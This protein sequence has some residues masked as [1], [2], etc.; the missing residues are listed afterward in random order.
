MSRERL[1]AIND[2]DWARVVER[3]LYLF[4]PVIGVGV[5]GVLQE[6]DPGVPGLQWGLVLFGTFGYTFLTAGMTV[7]LFLDA[8]RVRRQ[9]RASGQWQPNPWLNA[10]FAL[11]WAPVAGVVY[12][13][14][15]HRR[16]GTP[17]G[18]GGWWIVIAVSLAAT[19][20][21]AVAAAIGIVLAVPGL[22]TSAVGLAGA[23]AVGSFPVAIHQD[24]AYVCT[25]A[26][27][28]RP[29]PGLYLGFAFLGLF[30]PPVLP[31]VAGYYLLRRRR[32]IGTP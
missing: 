15:R 32:T 1:P 19:L 14:R 30:V 3:L 17:P 24:A 29:N 31:I 7:A 13:L 20:F 8:R 28:W 4:P 6:S 11:L 5:V 16:F 18:W 22:V 25:R 21:G 12:L 27:S 10:V 26:S 9:P 2:I 23:V